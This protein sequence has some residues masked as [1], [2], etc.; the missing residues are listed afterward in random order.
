MATTDLLTELDRATN[1]LNSGYALEWRFPD[2]PLSNPLRFQFKKSWRKFDGGKPGPWTK[3]AKHWFY[4]EFTFPEKKNGIALKDETAMLFVYGWMPFTIW[5][6]GQE[7]FKEKHAWLATGPI[8]DPF[9]FAI[10]PGKKH[11]FILCIEPTE[12]PNQAL[13]IHVEPKIE[14]CLQLA[15]DTG[16]AAAQIRYAGALARTAAEKALV[17]KAK[18][19]LDRRSLK[20]ERWAGVL[21]SVEKMERILSP[22]A[23][24]AKATTVHLVGHSHIDMDWMWT[25]NDTVHC[26]RRDLK[27]VTDMM[28]DYPDLTFTHSQ[29]PT[30][31]VCQKMD[32]DAFAKIRRRIREGRWE[33]AAG[34]W[35]EGDLNMA[36]GESIARHMLYAADWTQRHLGSKA[37]VLWE[38]DTFGHPGNMPQLAKLGEHDAYFHWRCNPDPHNAWPI[39]TWTGIDGTPITAFSEC[40]GADLS[41]RAL[42]SRATDS[43]R[44][45]CRNTF[46]VWGMGDHG[47]ALSRHQLEN[48]KRFRDK[49]LIPTLRFSTLKR[50][51]E[52]VRKENPRLK[53]AKG[54]TYTLF[55]GCFTTHATIKRDNRRCE[56]AL[57][58]AETLSALAGLNR[59]DVLRDA[60]T[61]DLF[62]HFH[63]IFDGAA[64]HDTYLNAG[65]RSRK[66]LATAAHVTQESIR[67]L[68]RPV[69]GGAR[70][71]VLNPLGFERTEPVRAELP[72]GTV[73][74]KDSR[75]RILPV[76]KLDGDY[77]FIAEGIPAFSRQTYEI[78]KK[79]PKGFNGSPVSVHDGD[80]Y[81]KVETHAATSQLAK[82][83]GAIASYVD[84]SLGRE[85]VAYGVPIPLTHVP[86]THADLALNVFQIRDEAHNAMTAWLINDILKE[87]NLLRGADVHL[88]ETGPVFARFRVT[89]K[90]RSSRIE[91]DILYYRD[92]P[93]VDFEA[94]IDWREKGNAD[95]GVPQLKV[96]FGVGLAAAR[97][98]TEGPFAVRDI[99]ADGMEM[100]TQNWVDLSGD[101][102]G[103]VLCNDSKHGIDALGPRLRMTLL[104][105]PY[106]PDPETDNGR[107][108][109]RFSMEP[110]GPRL[111]NAA[112]IRKGMAFNRSP[113]TALTRTGKRT[114]GKPNLSL[115]GSDSVVCTAL[116]RAEHSS[117]LLVRL[118]ET[119]GKACRVTVS[120]GRGMASAQQ[121]NFL[122]NPIGG[123]TPLAGGKARLSFRPFEVKT[124]L[125]RCRGLK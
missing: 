11:R 116:R 115:Q 102:F 123:T 45:G 107:H 64:V 76:Q 63:D 38:P 62:N 124:L 3:N 39:W 51:L 112:L 10:T 94:Q 33:N 80:S 114:A 16:A 74:L 99:P 91:E 55:E 84:K 23:A 6:D 30:Y 61:L 25:W 19:A 31:K 108:V 78:L 101:G 46:H 66:A 56:G 41:P 79:A 20:A 53:G 90:F 83:S 29:V 118:F 21:R 111:S 37:R 12:L 89:H 87:E 14:R 88:V 109:V 100:P 110:H 73:A 24:R 40:Y 26:V 28:D 47:G 17:E 77:V 59:T 120:L 5:L 96:S 103:L 22:L 50:L 34:T 4:A 57:L 104:R 106:S 58:T 117:E 92:F 70:L 7:L 48:L 93:R 113:L 43:L 98:R 97:V 54:Q 71:T 68:A 81:F 44:D 18:A 42:V 35:V 13:S 9:P 32:P 1:E 75:G 36:G 27:S 15:V 69:R 125:V 95:V 82:A 119:S 121:V 65:A 122:E 49:P 72:A 2:E 52:A 67:R 85:L 8:A 60:W 105:N 86:S